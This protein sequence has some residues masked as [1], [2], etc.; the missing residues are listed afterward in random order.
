M[1][2]ATPPSG[3]V[4]VLMIVTSGGVVTTSEPLGPVVVRAR[5]FEKVVSACV[6]TVLVLADVVGVTTTTATKV[7]EKMI[8]KYASTYPMW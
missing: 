8:L 2:V 5:G 4:D 1:R 3:A 7:R 6:V